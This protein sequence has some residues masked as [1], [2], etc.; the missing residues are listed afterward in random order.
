[1][2]IGIGGQTVPARNLDDAEEW[3]RSWDSQASGGTTGASAALA[4]RVAGLAAS[5]TGGEGAVRVRVDSS[6]N[7]TSLGLD[8]RV[9]RLSGDELAAE[10]L[11]TMHRAQAGLG[12]QVAVAVDQTVGADS[13]TGKAVL[14]SFAQRFPDV[15]D[16]PVAPV[17]PAPPPFPSFESRPTLPHQPPGNGF[18]SGR[19]SRAR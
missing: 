14:E 4:D 12:A 11:R 10:I 16:E 5:A 6:G 7:V 15:P 3:V 17:M 9:H 13:E 8:D 1:M 19:D 18:E 2:K